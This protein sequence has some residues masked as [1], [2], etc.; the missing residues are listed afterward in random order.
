MSTCA[1]HLVEAPEGLP[2][3]WWTSSPSPCN[4]QSPCPLEHGRLGPWPSTWKGF[5]WRLNPYG[6]AASEGPP[7]LG[8]EVTEL[9]VPGGGAAP[10]GPR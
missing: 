7:P 1:P 8:G 4:E 10:S 6:A 2:R 5:A 9:S 3:L